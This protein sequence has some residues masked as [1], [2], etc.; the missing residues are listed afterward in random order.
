[1]S[2]W[3]LPPRILAQLTSVKSFDKLMEKTWHSS[4]ERIAITSIW[5]LTVAKLLDPTALGILLLQQNQKLQF[6]L[7]ENIILWQPAIC[8]KWDKSLFRCVLPAF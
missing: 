1:M 3:M 4:S 5:P 8:D 7:Y 2:C 6:P